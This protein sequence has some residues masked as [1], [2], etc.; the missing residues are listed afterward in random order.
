MD[1]PE[2]DSESRPAIKPNWDDDRQLFASLSLALRRSTIQMSA[3]H[4]SEDD[5]QEADIR[6][7][8]IQHIVNQPEADTL[9]DILAGLQLTGSRSKDDIYRDIE[10]RFLLPKARL[11]DHWLPTYQV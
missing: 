1:E 3:E 8:A 5:L 7:A 10:Q 9:Q 2:E 6:R 4:H 11:P